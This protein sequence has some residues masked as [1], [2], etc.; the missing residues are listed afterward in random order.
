MASSEGVLNLFSW[1][2]FGD[3]NDRIPGHPNSIE[4]IVKYDEDTLITG[5]E[6]GLVRA[7]SVCPNRIIAILS[8]PL[9]Q[10]EGFHI[11]C[12]TVSHDRMLVAS[13]S[14]DDIVKIM[15]ISQLAS[16]PKDGS[17]NFEAYEATLELKPN[18]GKNEIMAEENKSG[19]GDWSSD[20]EDSKKSDDSSDDSDRDDS[21]E[22]ME[23]ESKHKPKNKYLNPKKA[24]VAQSQ[25]MVR[26]AKAKD[27]FK[28]L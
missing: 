14:P 15:D 11:Q 25:K 19:S 21:D 18:H 6:D 13:C 9:D 7:V 12:V 24:N 1:D 17:F 20:S 26:D 3:C 4:C 23:D 2:W 22:S 27:F 16:R 5:G 8:D 28:D 10:E